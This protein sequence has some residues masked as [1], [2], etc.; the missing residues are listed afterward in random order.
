MK[1]SCRLTVWV[2]WIGGDQRRAAAWLKEQEIG[3]IPFGVVS[4]DLPE[5]KSWNIP[6]KAKNTLVLVQR[7]ALDD[8]KAKVVIRGKGSRQKRTKG[9][10]AGATSG[11]ATRR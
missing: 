1:K 11:R 7:N 8:P 9:N 5:L 4:A 6:P 10:I 3:N 2:F